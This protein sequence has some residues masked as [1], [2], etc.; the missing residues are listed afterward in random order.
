MEFGEIVN[1]FVNNGIGVGC[2]IFFCLR[3]WAFMKTLNETLASLKDS[4]QLIQTHYIDKIEN[5]NK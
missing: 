4:L 2:V 5:D 1:L 3:D